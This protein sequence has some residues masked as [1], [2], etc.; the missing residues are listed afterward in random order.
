MKKPKKRIFKIS[1][2][3]VFILVLSFSVAGS[4]LAEP[5]HWVG[6]KLYNSSTWNDPLN[7]DPNGVP[8]KGDA[9]LINTTGDQ[10]S[11]NNPLNPTLLSVRLDDPESFNSGHPT[12][13]QDALSLTTEKTEVGVTNGFSFYSH[14]GG[15]HRILIGSLYNNGDTEKGNLNIGVLAGSSGSYDLVD[16]VLSVSGHEKVGIAGY[17]QMNQMS[18]N[19]HSAGPSLQ[20]TPPNNPPP[21]T[22]PPAGPVHTVGKNLYLG[23]ESHLDDQGQEI[24]SYGEVNIQAGSLTVGGSILV[25]NKGRGQFDQTN[26]T[27]TVKGNDPGPLEN[28]IETYEGGGFLNVK[29]MKA[30]TP[31]LECHISSK[32]PGLI[33]GV[34]N[35]GIYTLTGGNLNVNYSEIIGWGEGSDESS[36][37]QTDGTHKIIGN[38]IIAKN[39][40]NTSNYFSLFGTSIYEDLPLEGLVDVGGYTSAGYLGYGEFL[41]TGGKVKV[42]GYDPELVNLSLRTASSGNPSLQCSTTQRNYIGLTI[43][44]RGSGGFFLT[45]GELKVSRGE[46]IGVFKGSDGYFQQN[47]GSHYVGEAL[48]IALLPDSK[49]LYEFND[50]LLVARGGVVNNDTFKMFSGVLQAK[51]T[52][53]GSF[54]VAKPKEPAPGEPAPRIT[55]PSVI[56]DFVNQKN[57]TLTLTDTKG[58]FEKNFYNSGT[59]NS[60]NTNNSISTPTFKNLTISESGVLTLGTDEI[61]VNG[62]LTNKSIKPDVW[63]TD[64]ALLAFSGAGTHYFKTGNDNSGDWSK[65]FGWGVL[66]I[67]DGAFLRLQGHLYAKEIRAQVDGDK[68]TNLFG[69]YG[70][71][72][73]YETAVPSI[74]GK[75]L[76]SPGGLCVGIFQGGILN[77]NC[78]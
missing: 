56:G 2:G 28:G 78:Q 13:S 26:G 73:F 35:Y 71:K 70:I 16:A 12:L 57:A 51:V 48:T 25:G 3:L 66:D 15:T 45:D 24:P 42:R 4:V 69:F 33:V 59:I 19:L 68:V 41:Q 22:P 39:S 10:V 27:V 34:N 38:L 46:A 67:R 43:G 18:N 77:P 58:R 64:Q 60:V 50:G 65:N 74:E 1:G 5:K 14:T 40:T 52:N 7:W 21:V 20:C 8:K 23:I 53:N 37:E 32:N 76:F 72:V 6:N 63:N 11:Y 61:T 62:N 75:K 29:R 47:S 17:G 30:A 54:W 36:F 9:V 31:S 49:G 44:R 55:V